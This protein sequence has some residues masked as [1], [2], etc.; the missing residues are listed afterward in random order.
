[1]GNRRNFIQK[2]FGLGPGLFAAP[3][4]FADPQNG[5]SSRS[6]T[7]HPGPAFNMPV[8]TTD[9]GDMPYTMDGNTRVFH[10]TAE[11]VKQ[12]I[13]PLKTIDARGLQWQC[14]GADASG[15]SR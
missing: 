1:M 15:E 14:S 13:G 9:I 12:K 10:L 4:L 11:V 7:T 8:V 2:A 5:S 6:R 3:T